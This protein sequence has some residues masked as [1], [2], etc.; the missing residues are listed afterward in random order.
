M[1]QL[2]IGLQFASGL[3]DKQ[4]T[5]KDKLTNGVA[6][7]WQLYIKRVCLY[8]HSDWKTVTAARSSFRRFLQA[9][10]SRWTD[11]ATVVASKKWKSTL[12]V[13]FS[14]LVIDCWSTGGD[15][16]GAASHKFSFLKIWCSVAQNYKILH[17]T[18]KW[19]TNIKTGQH[20]L[21]LT[22]YFYLLLISSNDGFLILSWMTIFSRSKW[23][24]MSV[25]GFNHGLTSREPSGWWPPALCYQ[26]HSAPTD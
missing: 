21:K 23:L 1:E 5:A 2:R 6:F 8:M 20:K 10:G 16:S 13:V 14:A 4:K 3:I 24:H 19:P 25:D 12:S 15:R 17:I 9:E 7:A 18:R 22:A 11:A 26:G